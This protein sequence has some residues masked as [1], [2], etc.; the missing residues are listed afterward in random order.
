MAKRI[1]IV[2]SWGIAHVC[3]FL[4][5]LCR[6][7]ESDL[8]IDS[9][10]PR[11]DDNQGNECGVD[12]VFRISSSI[13][14]RRIYS[15]RKVGTY[16]KIKAELKT[17]EKILVGNKYDLVNIHFLPKYSEKYVKIA[18]RNGVKIMLTPLGSDVLRISDLFLPSLQRAFNKT[19]FVSA[20]FITGFCS[21]VKELFN[22]S[23]LKMIDLGYGSETISCIVENKDKCTKQELAA[24]LNIPICDYYITCGYNASKAQRHHLMIDGII[25]NKVNLPPNTAIVI[26]LTYGSDKEVIKQSILTQIEGTG[27]NVVFLTSFMTTEQVAALRLITDLFIHIQTTDAYNASLQE[28]ILADTTCINGAWLRYPSLQKYGSP[29]YECESLEDLPQLLSNILLARTNPISIHPSI[30]TEI[31]SNSWSNRIKGWI[32]FYNNMV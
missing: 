8:V 18:H 25:A 19:D 32:Q 27:L 13:I 23:G 7:K 15:I 11:F 24:C 4:D 20:K 5:V 22:V 26:P 1:L 14:E 9:F 31:K 2:G 30:L 3:R 12:N 28:F 29:Y 16:L 21:Q 10:D 17:F 6:N